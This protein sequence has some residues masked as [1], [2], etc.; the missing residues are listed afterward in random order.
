M[1]L[2]L[3]SIKRNKKKKE[4]TDYEHEGAT[5]YSTGSIRLA[6]FRTV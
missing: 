1:L 4:K 2:F 6:H 3:N 5:S